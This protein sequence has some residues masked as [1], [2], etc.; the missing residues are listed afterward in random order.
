MEQADDCPTGSSMPLLQIT[1]QEAR[2][3]HVEPGHLSA[4]LLQHGSMQLRWYAPNHTDPQ[5]PHDRDELY[6]VV[7]GSALFMRAKETIPFGEEEGME[8]HGREHVPVE[9]GDVLFVPAGTQHRFKAMSPDF[10]TWVIFY[11]PEGG[12]PA[13]LPD[14]PCLPPLDP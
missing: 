12:E 7:T 3:A 11:G 2:E 4:L 5:G 14:L 13:V 8:L 1:P 10:G 6:V 9:P